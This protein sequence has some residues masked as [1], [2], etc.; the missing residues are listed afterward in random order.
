MQTI[1]G[2][3]NWEFT[4]RDASDEIFLEDAPMR[5]RRYRFAGSDG[6]LHACCEWS[7]PEG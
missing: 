2:R 7:D 6:A 1:S 3:S 4:E 5:C